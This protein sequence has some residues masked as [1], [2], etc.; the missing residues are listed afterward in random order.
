V[1]LNLAFEV[2][3][4]TSNQLHPEGE[5]ALGISRELGSP[6]F[7]LGAEIFGKAEKGDGEL[8]VFAF[9]GP[10]VSWATGIDSP[11]HGIWVTVAAGRGITNA[12]RAYYGRVIVGLQF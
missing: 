3:R 5:Y 10:A 9:A 2:E 6:A 12:S 11:L 1:A 8:E 4:L 7:K